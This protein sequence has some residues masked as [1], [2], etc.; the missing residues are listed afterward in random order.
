M[1]GEKMEL[2]VDGEGGD[3]IGQQ[4]LYKNSEFKGFERQSC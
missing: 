1:R 4:N 2:R 3:E